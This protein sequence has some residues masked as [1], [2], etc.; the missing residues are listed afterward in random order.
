MRVNVKAEMLSM[1]N[2]ESKEGGVT[3]EDWTEW[4]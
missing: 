4:I 2:I 1:F 3:S